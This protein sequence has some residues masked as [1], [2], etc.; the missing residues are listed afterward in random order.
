VSDT[1]VIKADILQRKRGLAYNQQTYNTYCTDILF[2]SRQPLKYD[3]HFWAE[4]RNTQNWW[5]SSL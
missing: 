2:A 4:T 5:R 3:L 1:T